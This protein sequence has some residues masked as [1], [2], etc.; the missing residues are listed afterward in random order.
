MRQ[1]F[2]GSFPMSGGGGIYKKIDES[3]H[4]NAGPHSLLWCP[5]AIFRAKHLNACCTSRF[6]NRNAAVC[7]TVAREGE[8]GSGAGELCM[9]HKNDRNHGKKERRR[10][11]HAKQNRRHLLVTFALLVSRLHVG[12]RLLAHSHSPSHIS[13]LR[14]GTHETLPPLR[15]SLP[16]QLAFSPYTTLSSL[17]QTFAAGSHPSAPL[18]RY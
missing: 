1:T 5:P 8:L 13:R 18:G 9:D 7:R 12:P 6:F 15:A 4:R 3:Q 10:F 17:Q 11:S 14:P 16:P 2:A